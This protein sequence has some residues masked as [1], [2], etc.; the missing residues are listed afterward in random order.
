MGVATRSTVRFLLNDAMVEL[1][2]LA[3]TQTLLGFPAAGAADAR[4]ERRLRGG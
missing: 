4:V 2:A 1:S 3:P